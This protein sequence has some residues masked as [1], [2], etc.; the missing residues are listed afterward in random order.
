MDNYEDENNGQKA[1][2]RNNDKN[3][4]GSHAGVTLLQPR[5]AGQPGEPTGDRKSVV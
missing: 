2:K 5:T 1:N 4:A 3:D